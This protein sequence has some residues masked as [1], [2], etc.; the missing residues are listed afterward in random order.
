M[1]LSPSDVQGT[2]KKPSEPLEG[3]TTSGGQACTWG[4]PWHHTFL[5]PL[6]PIAVLSDAFYANCFLQPL[7]T[8]R[9]GG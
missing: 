4:S 7:G 1:L 5:M 8:R 6:P 2:Q 9:I 3:E